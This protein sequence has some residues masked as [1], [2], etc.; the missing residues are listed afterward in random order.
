[1]RKMMILFTPSLFEN[2]LG[3]VVPL[4]FVVGMDQIGAMNANQFG[5]IFKMTS[6]GESHGPAMGVVVDGCPSGVVFDDALLQLSLEL[7]R[8]GQSDVV[9]SRNELDK[10]RVLSGVFE[11]KTLGT[12]IAIV[13]ENK[14]QRSKDYDDIKSNPR[15]GH[16]D[17]VWQSKFSHVDHRGGGRSSGRETL[18]RVIAGAIAEMLIRHIDSEIQVVAYT[19]SVGD[20][21]LTDVQVQ[22]FIEQSGLQDLVLSSKVRCP[23]RELSNSIESRLLEA[24]SNGESFG[25]QVTLQ[26]LGLPKGLGEPVFAKLKSEL[27]AGFM[28]V[29]A[30]NGVEFGSGFK[31]STLPGTEFHQDSLSPLYGGLRGGMSTGE[32]LI[33]RVAFKPTSSVMDVAKK[34]RHDPCIVPRATSVIRAMAL[35]TI[36]DMLLMRRLN[37]A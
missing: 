35:I 26:A 21:R 31:G 16:A 20:L 28:S 9:S 7:R 34:G 8:P 1:M 10:A 13:V 23:D 36:A 14:D 6:F 27:A 25:G 18:S 22:Q 17:D 29:G 4:A 15:T 30:T 12:P 11:G 37:Q 2:G 32:P 19:S 24:K 3:A 33:A 5:R